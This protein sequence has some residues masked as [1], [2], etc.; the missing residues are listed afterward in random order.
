MR[1][2]AAIIARM[3]EKGSKYTTT[4]RGIIINSIAKN[5]RTTEKGTQP[6]LEAP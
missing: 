6:L 1:I 2:G 3:T 4:I 5:I